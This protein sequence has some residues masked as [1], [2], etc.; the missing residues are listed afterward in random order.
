MEIQLLQKHC[1]I[2]FR[3]VKST[4]FLKKSVVYN[5]LKLYYVLINFNN[6]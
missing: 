3:S 5:D 4:Y 1:T 6:F 2:Y